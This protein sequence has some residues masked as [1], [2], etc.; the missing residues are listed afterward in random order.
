MPGEG[1]TQLIFFIGA[2][3]VAVGVIG[4]VTINVQSISGSYGLKSK[5]LA[6]Q[7]KTDITIINDPGTN[8][9]VSNNYS[10]YV[11]NTGAST[12]DPTTV[13]MFV[14][15]KYTKNLTYTIMDGGSFWYPTYVLRL[16]YSTVDNPPLSGIDHSVRVV[17]GNGVFDSMAFRT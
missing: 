17:A 10:F 8:P 16:N 3:V 13:N 14:D 12:L 5:A 1:I 2:I 4:A 11:K 15:G 9:I 7:L 6:D